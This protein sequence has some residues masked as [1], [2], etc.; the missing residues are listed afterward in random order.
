MLGWFEKAGHLL[1][2]STRLRTLMPKKMPERINA[3]YGKARSLRHGT[4]VT[5][6][7]R[8]LFSARSEFRSTRSQCCCPPHPV[9]GSHHLT[10]QSRAILT[11]VESGSTTCLANSFTPGFKWMLVTASDG[12]A[13]QRK[14]KLR[15]GAERSGDDCDAVGVQARKE[16]FSLATNSSAAARAGSRQ[17]HFQLYANRGATVLHAQLA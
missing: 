3:D 4:G 9:K 12:F 11:A 8:R 1:M 7:L 13:R 14:Q 15:G 5:V 16:N 6:T 17:F 10:A 2:C